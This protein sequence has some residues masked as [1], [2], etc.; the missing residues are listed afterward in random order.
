MATLDNLTEADIRKV[1]DTKSL[2]R[3]R[4]YVDGVRAAVRNGRTLRAEVGKNRY[5]NVEI[6][7]LDSGIA[8][9][10]SCPY[11]WG[12]YCKHVGAL[13]LKWIEQPGSF[14]VET[15]ATATVDA[16]IETFTVGAPK[17]AVPAN[18]PRWL[19]RPHAARL[20]NDDDNLRIWLGEYR[21]QELR[22]IARHNGWPLKGTRKDDLIQQIISHITQPGIALKSLLKLDAEHR[23]VLDAL[24]LLYPG[25]RFQTKHAALL[26]KHWGDLKLHSKIET[27]IAHLCDT[28]LVI[29]GEFDHDYWQKISFI[30]RSVLRALPPLLADRIAAT[31]LSDEANN[32]VIRGQARPFLQRTQQ[33]LLLLEQSQP[34]LRP[35]MPRPRL[36]KFHEFLQEWDYIPEEV[37]DAQNKNQFS[38]YDPQLNA[39]L[40]LTV[41]PPSPALPDEAIQ[42]LAPLAGDETQLNFIYHL[43]LQ[44]KLLQPGSPVTV[45]RESKE[46]FLRHDEAGQWAILARAYFEL[47]TWSELWLM[48]AERPSIQLKRAQSRYYHPLSPDG[49][50]QILGGMRGQL[51]QTLAHLPDGVWFSPQDIADLLSALWPRFD[52]LA[53]IPKSYYVDELPGWFLAENGRPLDTANNKADWHKAQGAFIQH[54]IQGPLHWLGLADIRSEDGRLTAFRLHGLGDLFFD[55]VDAVPLG[56]AA[57]TQGATA[58]SASPAAITI[59]ATTIMVDP[60]AVSAQVHSYLDSIAL[61]TEA[62]TNRFI[63][64]L[65]ASA[66]HQAFENGQTVDELL[67]GWEKWLTIPLNTPMPRTIKDQLKAWH[68]A[69]GQ[70]RLYENVTVIEFGDEYALAEMKAATSLE[71]H[72][73]AQISPTLVII[74]V[75][76]VELLVSELEKAGYT[77]KQTNKV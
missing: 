52:G 28:G 6:D 23:R 30:P 55:K 35:P 63:Y 2:K 34:S 76:S 8:A 61:L 74:P 48:L 62:R 15:T 65:S 1:I 29:P 67:D 7:V 59:Q 25:I 19:Q 68:N 32:G 72:L 26:A 5:Y 22:Q 49:M 37:R 39:Q 33:I 71:K 40:S 4:S 77:P 54:V 16:I 50:Y 43:L 24:G 53:W 9:I 51:L 20:Q 46:Q 73:V 11:T 18:K 13:L 38:N 12:G 21:V 66:V 42:R 69:Y 44:A 47:V 31:T 17:T 64:Q 56:D 14:V 58:V 57:P 3:A 36:E 60:T 75:S 41:P 70:V 27:Y 45:W 10:C